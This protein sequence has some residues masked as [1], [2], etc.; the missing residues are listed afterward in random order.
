MQ[1]TPGTPVSNLTQQV[2]APTQE[3]KTM[4]LIAHFGAIFTWILAPLVVYLVKKDESKYVAFHALQALYFS[5]ATSV[6]LM[7][8]I[9]LF[10]GLILVPIPLIF[11]ILAGVKVLNGD[12][13]EYPVV[14][15]MARN[16]VYKN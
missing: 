6:I 5:I 13:Y 8:T 7:I 9:P 4:A 10:I 16:Q 14:G 1:P 11:Y 12:D 15:K 3:E 2:A